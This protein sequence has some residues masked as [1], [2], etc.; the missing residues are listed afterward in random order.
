[1][2]D[3]ALILQSAEEYI[4]I[5]PEAHIPYFTLS[6]LYSDEENKEKSIKYIKAAAAR[7]PLNHP[8]RAKV[9]NALAGTY[10]LCQREDEAM[11]LFRAATSLG[12]DV[13]TT[14]MHFFDKAMTSK[15][16]PHTQ[17]IFFA[18]QRAFPLSAE[19]VVEVASFLRHYSLY[20]EAKD[21]WEH[22]FTHEN[23]LSPERQGFF[24]EAKKKLKEQ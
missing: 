13:W 14:A 24:N 20:Q 12:I 19:Q 6:A 9:I 2:N 8:D 11:E 4:S 5:A 10:I 16:Y 1:M 21:I 3:I 23:E 7:C 15:N 18:Y 22:L 17:R